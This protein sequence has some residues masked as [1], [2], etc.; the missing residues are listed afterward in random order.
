V[1]N[2]PQGGVNYGLSVLTPPD[3]E[4]ITLAR[5]KLHLRIDQDVEDDILAGWIG[6]ARTFTE[7]HANR[8]WVS[9]QLRMTMA[10][11]PDGGGGSWVQNYIARTTG[12]TAAGISGAVPLPVEPVVSVDAVRYHAL[13]GT[14]TA[15]VEDVNYQTWLDHSPPLVAPAPLRSWPVVQVGKLQAVKID[16]TAGYGGAAAVPEQAKAA[17]QLCLSYWYENRGDGTD[18]TAMSGL[19]QTLG[20]PPGAKRL[21][22]LMETHG[23]R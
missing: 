18:P 6:A 23:Y 10:D 16:F 8:R 21:L 3:E 5:A 19:P 4:P 14:L 9:Q 13:N 22:D 17:M 20:M 7:L 12:L 2:A 15:L 1:A 11:W